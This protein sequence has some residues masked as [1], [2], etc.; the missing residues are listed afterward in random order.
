M[1]RDINLLVPKVKEA[2]IQII[3]DCKS[4]G[5]DILIT[6]TLRTLQDQAKL[7]RQSRT[8]E[9]IRAKAKNFEERGF[10]FLAKILIDVGP[11]RG[12]LGRH[13]TN[14]GPGESFHGYAE[15]FD[16]VP[17]EN[18]ICLWD[19]KKYSKEWNLYGWAVRKS[20]LIWAGDWTSFREFA[21]AQLRQGG[22]PLKIY[23]PQQ[24]KQILEQNGL[25]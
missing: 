3:A 9:E 7:Y 23:T 5:V 2:C 10:D 19:T 13:V 22:N 18:R 17:V 1:S 14:A 4:K 24:V 20:G 16:G 12:K 25:I 21:H 8:I 15:A 11:Q 6:D